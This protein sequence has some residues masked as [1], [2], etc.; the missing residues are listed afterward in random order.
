MSSFRTRSI[1]TKGFTIVELLVVIVVIGILASV[2]IISYSNIRERAIIASLQS[3]LK[4]ASTILEMDKTT[5]IDNKYPVILNDAN[6]GNGIEAS[7]NNTFNY[8]YNS[9]DNTYVL[10]I[11][12]GSISYHITSENTVP[13]YGMR[14]LVLYEN[15]TENV[16]WTAVVSEIPY[17]CNA[18]AT[19]DPGSMYA[20]ATAGAYGCGTGVYGR[21]DA[22]F[23]VTGFNTIRI[24]WKRWAG[25]SN[26]IGNVRAY[27]DGVLT[28]MNTPVVVSSTEPEDIYV[29]DLDVSG[30]DDVINFSVG[31]YNGG[32]YMWSR[33]IRIYKIELVNI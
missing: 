26:S 1:A 3:D 17:A 7:I 31:S 4:N 10:T 22:S 25:R 12:N 30:I 2:T 28:Y 16:A 27:I 20:G 33:N 15:G 32:V 6:G 19:K 21:F 9:G 29:E 8:E 5:D 23:D 24:T 13:T 11:S 18:W 14:G